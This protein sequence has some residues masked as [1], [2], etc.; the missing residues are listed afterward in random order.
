[1]AE[2]TRRHAL[3]AFCDALPPGD[4]D[5]AGLVVRPVPFCTHI[6]IRGDGRAEAFANAVGEATGHAPPLEANTFV[7]HHAS[8]CWTGPDEWLIVADPANPALPARLRDA[9]EN[10]HAAVTDLSGGQMLIELSGSRVRDALAAGC[11]LD[12]HP[13]RFA[14]GRCA[15]TTLARAGMLIMAW[16]EAPTYRIVVRRSF[17]DYVARWLDHVGREFGVRWLPA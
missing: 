16:D 11:T 10:L 8:I 5:G 12:L 9:T 4:R 15:Q 2:P 7:R 13:G 14:A 17:A 1:M 6:N 3:Q